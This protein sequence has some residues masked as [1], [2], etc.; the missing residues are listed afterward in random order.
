MLRGLPHLA[1]YM[2]EIKDARR[3]IPDP[4]SEL[5]FESISK[6]FP[7]PDAQA[8][9]LE[10]ALSFQNNDASIMGGSGLQQQFQNND[11]SVMGGS[12]LQQQFQSATNN[13]WASIPQ[14]F[15][16]ASSLERSQACDTMRAN[17]AVSAALHREAEVGA[18]EQQNVAMLI[19]LAARRQQ[20]ADFDAREQ[21]ANPGNAALALLMES[22]VNPPNQFGYQ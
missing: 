20:Q 22:M 13:N 12:G 19:E 7:L 9:A 4:E 18:Q 15:P 8:A 14:M 3:L 17:N 1:K 10:L 2:P 21:Q 5:D 16:A 11:A 6:V